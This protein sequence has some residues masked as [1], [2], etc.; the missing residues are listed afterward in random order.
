MVA[1]SCKD[2][3]LSGGFGEELDK[4]GSGERIFRGSISDM[5]AFSASEILSDCPADGNSEAGSWVLVIRAV[6]RWST[7]LDL[8]R[9]S[10]GAR[11]EGS[12]RSVD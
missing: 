9:R 5:V 2:C 12:G 1:S 10:V 7:S 11:L 4:E 3:A 6:V 8:S